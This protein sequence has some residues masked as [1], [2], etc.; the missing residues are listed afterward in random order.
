MWRKNSVGWSLV[1]GE[2]IYEWCCLPTGWELW[3][4]TPIVAGKIAEYDHE[5]SEDERDQ[6]VMEH[7]L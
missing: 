1:V 5:P 3:L 7:L 2:D 6:I 4:I